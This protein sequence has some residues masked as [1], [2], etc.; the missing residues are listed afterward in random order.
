MLS[1]SFQPSLPVDMSDFEKTAPPPD[2]EKAP[3]VTFV[4][5]T[6]TGRGNEIAAAAVDHNLKRQLKG[7]HVAMISIG[8][9][10]T[11]PTLLCPSI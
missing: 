1:S 11:H 6:E 9:A 5:H 2:A 4:N 7:R 10:S 3:S 8:G